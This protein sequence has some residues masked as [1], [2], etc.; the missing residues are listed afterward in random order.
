MCISQQGVD[1]WIDSRR[2]L[3]PGQKFAHW[4]FRGVMTRVEIGPED[5]AKGVCMVC[6]AKEAGD[7]KSVEKRKVRLPPAGNRA[8]LLAL[9]EF[10][11]SKIDIERREGDSADEGDEAGAPQSSAAAKVSAKKSKK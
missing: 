1:A 4:E 8:L 11:M 10:G 9:K 7:Y 6:K 5:F 2:H 3:T